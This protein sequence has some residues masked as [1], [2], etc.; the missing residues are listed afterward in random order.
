M[1]C[2]SLFAICSVLLAATPSVFG[3]ETAVREHV[4]R[5]DGFIEASWEAAE[6][7]PAKEAADRVYA[8][9]LF[10]DLVGRT[11]TP[12][13]L[14]TFLQ[15]GRP[16]KREYLVDNLLASED[17]VQH[18]TDL[19]DTVLM[20]R[21]ADN[22]YGQRQSSQWRAW[23]ER[24][25]RDN[26]SWNQAVAEM[27]LARPKSAED[28][29]AVWFL[30]ER[31]NNHQ[32]IAEAVAPAV[33]GF[34]IECA[35]C[36]DHMIASEIEQAHY[37]GLVAF[38][39]RGK[40]TKT[41]NGPRVSE[42]AIGGFSD[43]A[44]LEGS[45]S[46][47][48][49]TFLK[50]E[51]IDEARPA[52]DEKQEDSGDLYRDATLEGDPRVPLFS[53]REK[54]VEG[55]VED[56]PLIARAFVNRMW[57]ILMGRGIVHPFDEMDSQHDPS[58]PELL[59][60]LAQDFRDSN[61]NIRR[62]VKMIV[63]CR[64]YQ[65]EARA[66][67]GL[68]DPAQFAWYIERPLT[69]EQ[70][71][72]SIQQSLRGSFRNDAPLVSQIRRPLGEV[73]PD[74]INT[75]VANALF[76]SNNPALNDYIADSVGDGH[77]LTRLRGLESDRERAV[78]LFETILN[79]TPAEQEVDRVVEFVERRSDSETVDKTADKTADKKSSD[80][81]QHVVWALITGAEF[82]FNH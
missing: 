65:L 46:P 70:L 6:I 49:L 8:R 64:A 71:A 75:T 52:K 13:E 53:R 74:T 57:A 32:A 19:L 30:Y 40:N 23:L 34:R 55:V 18:L 77:L 43:F 47:N 29:G 2:T 76:L 10:L 50:A 3:E 73:L 22:V 69:A 33:F 26:R 66:P 62:L 9:R 14:K 16:A 45:S 61:Y 39:N 38:F 12:S 41:K 82:R 54:F 24:V 63:M 4:Q 51:Q 81:W 7:V 1:N 60:W 37:W 35:Q 15:D 44:N 56:H 5:I 17:H 28:R 72:R 36:H 78:A 80:A 31:N 25:I 11:P 27:L 79:R 68:E 42:S 58:H 20:G 48:L 21:A 67:D 59:D